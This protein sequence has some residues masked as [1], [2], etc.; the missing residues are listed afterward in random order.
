MWLA[1]SRVAHS[2]RP[3]NHSPAP[4]A[5]RRFDMRRCNAAVLNC[6]DLHRLCGL[7]PCI[8][9]AVIVVPGPATKVS[10]LVARGALRCWSSATARRCRAPSRGGL[11]EITLQERDVP[12]L[13]GAAQ[14][15]RSISSCHRC[16]GVHVGAAAGSRR[17]LPS[18]GCETERCGGAGCQVRLLGP[19]QVAAPLQP[20]APT[21]ASR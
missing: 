17:C 9:W 14:P 7:W 19:P 11:A 18:R 3:S 8:L 21:K 1:T 15:P 2:W 5:S 10:A 12:C 6:L 16:G 13:I 20:C 4:L